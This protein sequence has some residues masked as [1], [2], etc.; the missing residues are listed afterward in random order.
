MQIQC[1]AQI[2]QQKTT[3]QHVRTVKHNKKKRAMP[4][5]DVTTRSEQCKI[6]CQTQSGQQK[7]I[8]QRVC[9]VKH[10]KKTS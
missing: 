6:Q 10:K 1:Q 7:T 2:T 8:A 5:K 3:A 4:A 9:Q